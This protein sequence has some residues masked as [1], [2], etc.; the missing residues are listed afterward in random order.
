MRRPGKKLAL[1]GSVPGVEYSRYHGGCGSGSLDKQTSMDLA[2]PHQQYDADPGEMDPSRRGYDGY[3]WEPWQRETPPLLLDPVDMRPPTPTEDLDTPTY[4]DGVL[5]HALT[6]EAWGN[7]YG[8]PHHLEE[9]SRA[10][11]DPH[12]GS[13]VEGAFQPDPITEMVSELEQ[14]AQQTQEQVAPPEPPPEQ[15][16]AQQ[17]FDEQMQWFNQ[18]GMT[19]PMGPAM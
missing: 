11:G 13:V 18:F 6:I 5:L 16:L 2:Q 19:G 15:D 4:E 1:D 3:H 7:P 8:P 14:L 12:I 9:D 10:Q 17:I